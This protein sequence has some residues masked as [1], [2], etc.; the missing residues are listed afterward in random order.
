MLTVRHVHTVPYG[1]PY[2]G[3]EGEDRRHQLQHRHSM[4]ASLG[5]GELRI[6]TWT[7]QC[8]VMPA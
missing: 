1:E 7:A 4:L 8:N 5:T 3:Q 2:M 6:H